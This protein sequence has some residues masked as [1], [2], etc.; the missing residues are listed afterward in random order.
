MKKFWSGIIAICLLMLFAIPTFAAA[1]ITFTAEQLEWFAAELEQNG[2]GSPEEYTIAATARQFSFYSFHGPD[3]T[4]QQFAA[5]RNYRYVVQK[6]G[7]MAGIVSFYEGIDEI[8]NAWIRSVQDEY[9]AARAQL[10]L[11]LSA[12]YGN[13]VM[14]C[15]EDEICVVFDPDTPEVLYRFA[16][17]AGVQS[18]EKLDFSDTALCYAHGTLKAAN[19]CKVFKPKASYGFLDILAAKWYFATPKLQEWWVKIRFSGEGIPSAVVYGVI[20]AVI[21]T[22]IVIKRQIKR[23][24]EGRE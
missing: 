12:Y 14:Y 19:E 21:C 13:D 2:M 20:T 11:D 15:E 1:P 6:D 18:A 22:V 7:E 8:E 24:K 23:V 17:E 4:A 9:G 5:D 16:L 10:I 3:M